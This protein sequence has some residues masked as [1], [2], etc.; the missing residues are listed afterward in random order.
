MTQKEY[1]KQLDVHHIVRFADFTDSTQ[2]N[3]LEN[4]VSLCHV[5]HMKREWHD[6]PDIRK[7]S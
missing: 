2:A 4:L 1:G 6:Y 7:S 3:V 5:C